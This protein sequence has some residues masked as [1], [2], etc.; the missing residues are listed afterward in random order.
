[1]PNWLKPQRLDIY[2]P[3]LNIGVEYQGE[4]HFRPVDFGGKGP[5]FTQHQFKENLKRDNMKRI[6][7]LDNGCLLLEMKFDDDLDIFLKKLE[8]EIE[9]LQNGG[10]D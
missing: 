5:E 1:M 3:E 7:C 6:K 9:L 2:I 4:Q 10:V 8:N